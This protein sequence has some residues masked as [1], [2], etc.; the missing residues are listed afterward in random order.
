MDEPANHTSITAL[1]C[2]GTPGLE[3]PSTNSD[4]Y[5]FQSSPAPSCTRPSPASVRLVRFAGLFV[6][7]VIKNTFLLR[8]LFPVRVNSV[9]GL[10]KPR[11][12]IQS[13]TFV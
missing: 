9:S 11:L 7:L 6:V 2:P 1:A 8:F 5:W 3:L 10:N 4:G 12:T 13:G